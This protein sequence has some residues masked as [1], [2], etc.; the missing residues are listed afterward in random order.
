MNEQ[1]R[2]L[3]SAPSWESELCPICGRP[4]GC[5]HHVIPRS[6]GGT[7]GPTVTLCG[8][9]NADGC[10]GMVHQK[11][12]HLRYNGRWEWLHTYKAVKDDDIDQAAKWSPFRDWSSR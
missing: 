1:Q 11:K 9:G 12:L 10:H 6:A 3:M 8:S 4:V 7:D 2:K 5:R